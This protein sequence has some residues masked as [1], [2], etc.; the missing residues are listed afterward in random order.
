MHKAKVEISPNLAFHVQCAGQRTQCFKIPTCE[1]ELS[2]QTQLKEKKNALSIQNLPW[3]GA[4]RTER[5]KTLQGVPSLED[6]G[7]V[8]L[9][10]RPWL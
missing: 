8:S 9:T 10:M 6:G 2:L 7:Q 4:G 1:G 3:V 5:G